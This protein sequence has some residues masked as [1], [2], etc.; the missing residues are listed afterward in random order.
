MTFLNLLVLLVCKFT[1]FIGEIL[2]LFACFTCNQ[3]KVKKV[4]DSFDQFNQKRLQG[5]DIH[6]LR[7]LYK[8][9]EISTIF[10]QSI[11]LLVVLI[12]MLTRVLDCG[13]L[14]EIPAAIFLTLV[15]TV[16]SIL[17]FFLRTYLDSIATGE[18]YI[19]HILDGM[20]VDIN[21][22][23]LLEKIRTEKTLRIHLKF[24]MQRARLPYLTDLFGVYYDVQ[25]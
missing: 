3:G 23:P 24:G 13:V 22:L 5:V 10:F 16:L 6:T 25:F 19:L 11:P 14:L 20:T 17:K 8:Q 4:R 21:W 7:N 12:L 15:T 9:L 1:Y 18:S 2:V